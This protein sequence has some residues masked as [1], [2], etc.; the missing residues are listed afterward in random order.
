[1]REWNI[2]GTE[3]TELLGP[4]VYVLSRNDVI[5]YVGMSRYGVS[6]ALSSGHHAI[7]DE[8]RS[9]DSL[10]FIFCPTGDS[11]EL[12]EAKLILQYRPSLNKMTDGLLRKI[13]RGAQ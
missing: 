7:G 4:V 12:L 1:M 9:T 13:K 11:A 10:R 8:I 5:I 3:L 2:T 6:R